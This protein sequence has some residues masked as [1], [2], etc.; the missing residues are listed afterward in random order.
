M[1]HQ[2]PLKTFTR[3]LFF[4]PCIAC[5]LYGQLTGKITDANGQ[6]LQDVSVHLENTFVGTVSNREGV[7]HLNPKGQT[8]GTIVFTYLGFQTQAF[9]FDSTTAPFEVVL[10]PKIVQLNE[11]TLNAQENPAHAIIRAAQRERKK[12]LEESKVYTADFYSKGLFGLEN[13]PER[14]M[15]QEVG[16]LDGVLDSTRSGILYLSETKSKIFSER[17]NFKEVVYASKVSGNDNGFSFNTAED[18]DFNFYKNTLDFG[19]QLVS[20]IASNAFTYYRYTLED[21]FYAV[22]GKLIN[23]IA[24]QPK[25]DASPTFEGIIYIVED[26]WTLYGV[27]LT[28]EGKRTQLLGLNSMQLQQQYLYNSNTAQWRKANQVL[29]FDFSF[30]G[31]KGDG[32]FS[33]VYSNYNTAPQFAPKTF[34]RTIQTIESGANKKS[35]AYWDKQRPIP[36]LEKEVEDYMKKDSLQQLR[37]SEVYLDSIDRKNNRFQWSDIIQKEIQNST[38]NSRVKIEFPLARA[39]FNPIQGGTYGL[40]VSWRRD[41]EENGAYIDIGSAND[42]GASNKKH[43]P[44]INASYRFNS[45]NYNTLTF[46]AG[47]DLEQFNNRPAVSKTINTVANLFFKEHYAR[48]LEKEKIELQWSL[49][50]LEGLFTSYSVGYQQR[51]PRANTI[52]FSYRFTDRDYPEN[53]PRNSAV[54]FEQHN[55]LFQRLLVRYAFGYKLYKEPNKVYYNFDNTYPTL[56]LFLTNGSG[57]S[58]ERYNFTKLDLRLSHKLSL[59]ALGSTQYALQVGGFI[60]KDNPSFVDLQH[61]NG[62]ATFFA[63]TT[64]RGFNLLPYYERSTSNDYASFHLTHDFYKWGVGSWPL[65]KQLQGSLIT[66]IHGLAI[67]GERPY[68]EFNIGVGNLGFGQIR[69]LSLS[70]VKAFGA[71]HR[72]DGFFIGFTL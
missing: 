55:I 16:D 69:G 30:L 39:S 25:T 68:G 2:L 4:L 46:F 71:V 45:T 66:G 6:P 47:R 50:L 63:K 33:A 31:F 22:E 53:T 40:G 8:S 14:F 13:V 56:R 38:K 28:I 67:E 65:I 20:P 54:D 10:Q 52:N 34:N 41:W 15:G 51:T 60:Q 37:K 23:R 7:F 36:L 58:V 19:N 48:Y 72:P 29:D 35:T 43:Y 1:H 18:A 62:N 32:R 3:F 64:Y 49:Y 44:K 57:S 5:S 9:Q 11:V 24:V 27:D 12:H 42:Y 26:D 17:E 59:G 21:S 61:F 70:Y